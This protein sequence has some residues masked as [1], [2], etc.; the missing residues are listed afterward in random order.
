M[1]IDDNGIIR[2]MTAEELAAHE[3]STAD[4]ERIAAEQA[5]ALE[6]RKAPLRRLGLTEDEIDVVLGFN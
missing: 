4:L 6:A 1:K 5:V 2:D 3:A